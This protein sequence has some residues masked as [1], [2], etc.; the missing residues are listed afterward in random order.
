[1]GMRAL[2]SAVLS[3]LRKVE[4]NRS[5]RLKDVA[6]ALGDE[7]PEGYLQEGD[8]VVHLNLTIYGNQP[9]IVAYKPKVKK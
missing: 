2:E 9:V 4:N 1:M 5:I 8:K 6:W 3:E 7:L